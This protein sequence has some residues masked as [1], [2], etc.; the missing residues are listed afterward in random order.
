MDVSNPAKPEEV[1]FLDTSGWAMDVKVSGAKAYVAD[2][3]GGLLIVDTSDITKPT[4]L[5]SYETSGGN[6]TK[7]II[8]GGTAYLADCAIG[9]GI[10]KIST[11]ASP[12]E[13]GLYNPMGFG[14]AVAVFLATMPMLPPVPMDSHR[15]CKGSPS[16]GTSRFF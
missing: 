16:S 15:G 14:S 4:E 3:T 10:F 6:A 7:L 1:G 5:G 9:L 11:P 12:V 8:N 13:V 2:A